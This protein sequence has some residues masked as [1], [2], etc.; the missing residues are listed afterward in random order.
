ML[1]FAGHAT[2]NPDDPFYSRLFLT[3]N[4]DTG[5]PGIITAA[6]LY[7]GAFPHLK[8]AVLSACHTGSPGRSLSEGG[9]NLARPF[10]AAGAP[11]VVATLYQVLDQVETLALMDDFYQAWLDGD[12]PAQALQKAQRKAI[13]Q[14][15]S[16]GIWSA[17]QVFGAP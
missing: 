16:V 15:V 3:P 12:T 17:Y 9:G 4:P 2:V 5:S 13:L 14:G 6:Q 7:E 11:S 1:H 8:L 10:L